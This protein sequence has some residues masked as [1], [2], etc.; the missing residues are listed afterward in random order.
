MIK[1]L[2]CFYGSKLERD[3]EAYSK[4]MKRVEQIKKSMGDHYLL[5][6]HIPKKK[7][8]KEKRNG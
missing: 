1:L 2:D 7:L 6:K 8:T 3:L 4:M 5:A